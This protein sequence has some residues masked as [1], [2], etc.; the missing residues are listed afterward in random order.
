MR[1]YK[2]IENVIQQDCISALTGPVERNDLPTVQK[3][4]NCLSTEDR[5]MYQML[6][7]KLVQLAEKKNPG[8]D[9]QAMRAL[10]NN[11]S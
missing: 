4:L 1:L 10:L 6:G 2:N 7:L 5:Q 8:Q 11:F 9:Y 3:H